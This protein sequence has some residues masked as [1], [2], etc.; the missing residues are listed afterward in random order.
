MLLELD[1]PRG[2]P[3]LLL[4]MTIDEARAAMREWGEP[5]DVRGGMSPSL[6]VM[7]PGLCFDVF[8]HFEDDATVT[9]IEVWRPEGADTAVTW[10]GGDV[11]RTPIEQTLR[12][13]Q[14]FGITVD[15]SDAQGPCCPDLTLGFNMPDPPFIKAV[16]VAAPGYYTADPQLD[17]TVNAYVD[18]L[19]NRNG[20]PS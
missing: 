20:G 10:R 7:G 18:L 17:E 9:A 19:K 14:A 13:I 5:E 2:V 15:D 16:L 4:G 1:P 11:F 3:P 12:R 8:A 6:R